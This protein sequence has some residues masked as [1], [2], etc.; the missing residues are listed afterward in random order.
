M[1]SLASSSSSVSTPLSTS[2]SSTTCVNDCNLISPGPKLASAGSKAVDS[3]AAIEISDC[4]SDATGDIDVEVFGPKKIPSAALPLPVFSAKTSSSTLRSSPSSSTTTSTTT[5]PLH[6]RLTVLEV[7]CGCARLAAALRAVG[8]RVVGI[9]C[10]DNKDTTPSGLRICWMDLSTPQGQQEFRDLVKEL[11]PVYVHFA[12]PCGTATKA[13]DIRRKFEITAGKFIDPPPL[14]SDSQ[15]DGLPGLSPS[16]QA[17]VTTANKLYDFV[18]DAVVILH[19]MGIAWSIENPHSSRMWITSPFKRLFEAT[20]HKRLRIYEVDFHNCMHGGRRPKHSRIIYSGVDFSSLEAEC[21]HPK[22]HHMPWGLTKDPNSLFATA[23]ER[24]YPVLLCQRMALRVATKFP[25]TSSDP[26]PVLDDL[27]ATEHG[28]GQQR[29]GFSRLV[30]EFASVL[31]K[32][33]ATEKDFETIVTELAA[34]KGPLCRHTYA[35]Q[36]AI[37]ECQ[38]SYPTNSPYDFGEI[39]FF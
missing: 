24:R 13:R 30:E 39:L 10:K 14:R 33:V 29:R 17:R 36:C 6:Q 23:E 21:D 34:K 4:E 16:D 3:T 7:F 18:V 22:D 25:I 20:M 28:R 32:Q 2:V 5:T 38:C 31:H 8:F 37:G 27:T 15:P 19:T 9:D 26:P 11:K 35:L 1:T 12:P